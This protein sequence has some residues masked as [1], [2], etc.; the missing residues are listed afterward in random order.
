MKF[1]AWKTSSKDCKSTM[2]LDGTTKL[3]M[4]WRK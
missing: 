4:S 3:E 2:L 1:G